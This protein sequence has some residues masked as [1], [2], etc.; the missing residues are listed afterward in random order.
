VHSHSLYDMWW[1]QF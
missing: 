1:Q